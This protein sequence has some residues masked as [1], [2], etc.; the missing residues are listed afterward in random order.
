MT[1]LLEAAEIF[2]DLDT[3]D[4]QIVDML[5]AGVTQKE[6]A[7]LLGI[8]PSA[9]CQRANGGLRE[10]VRQLARLR[11]EAGEHALANCFVAAV[12]KAQEIL[13]CGDPK[14]ELR[15]AGIIISRCSTLTE[16]DLRKRLEALE[17]ANA[18]VN[19][20]SLG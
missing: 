18:I 6:I 7:A 19:D 9:I 4:R 2:D 3:K 10:K 1:E 17:A 15:A 14:L 12:L 16:N 13:T 5:A 20:S 8:S 11:L